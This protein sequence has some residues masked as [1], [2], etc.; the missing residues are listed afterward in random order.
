MNKNYIFLADD[1]E[2]DRMLFSE[3]LK[4]QRP[5]SIILTF[6]NGVDLMASLLDR[7]QKLPDIIFLDL[8][9]PL[10]NGEECLDDIRRELSL[11]FIP[12]IIYSTYLDPQKVDAVR[13]GGAN[14][15]LKKPESYTKLKESLEKALTSVLDENEGTD[16]EFIVR[17]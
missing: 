11:A 13:D 8:N 2:D 16:S 5:D 12:V 9:M 15:Y 14:K 7:D 1:D 3:A 10:M 4:E 6:D 17:C